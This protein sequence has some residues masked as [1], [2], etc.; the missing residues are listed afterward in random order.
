M[1]LALATPLLKVGETPRFFGLVRILAQDLPLANFFKISR[2]LSVE[3]SS[4]A[5]SSRGR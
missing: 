2:E 1:D 3:W 5:I 4:M